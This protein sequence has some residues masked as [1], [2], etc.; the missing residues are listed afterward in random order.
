MQRGRKSEKR[1]NGAL[2]DK[3]K[4]GNAG[5]MFTAMQLLP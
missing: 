1:A 2:T 5:L 3:K 4:P